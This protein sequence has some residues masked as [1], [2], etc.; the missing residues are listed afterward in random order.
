MANEE[1]KPKTVSDEISDENL[2]QITGGVSAIKPISNALVSEPIE[3][4]RV[5][6]SA[7]PSGW[8]LKANKNA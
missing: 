4:T 5:G 1:N 2:S 3:A 7:S 6:D 8:D